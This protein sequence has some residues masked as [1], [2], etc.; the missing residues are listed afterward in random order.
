[1]VNKNRFIL[2]FFN[3]RKQWS[4]NKTKSYWVIKWFHDF[5]KNSLWSKYFWP[6]IKS[7]I[8]CRQFR[9]GLWDHNQISQFREISLWSLSSKRNKIRSLYSK[10]HHR[11]SKINRY[12]PW[13]IKNCQSRE[14]CLIR[15]SSCFKLRNCWRKIWTDTNSRWISNWLR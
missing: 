6:R 13:P 9:C 10:F 2:L 14:I 8:I 11:S 1:M 3:S 12:F 15:K 4:S 5:L 7:I